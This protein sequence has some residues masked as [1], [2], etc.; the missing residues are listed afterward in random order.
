[1][2]YWD[3]VMNTIT[4][5]LIATAVL[6]ILMIVGVIVGV[7]IIVYRLVKKKFGKK[8][9]LISLMVIPL[10]LSYYIYFAIYPNDNFY[11]GEFRKIVGLKLPE[12]AEIL[13]KDASYHDL[14]GDYCSS[15]LIMLS[16]A[17]YQSILNFVKNDGKFNGNYMMMGSVQY[18]KVLGDLSENDMVY[19]AS[20]I[21]KED[22]YNF[23]G[24]FKDGKTIIIHFASS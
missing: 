5:I 22:R 1:M 14:H 12:S 8:P 24:F 7:I 23:I 21:E 6:F 16:E 9:A 19:E 11:R 18:N 15:A 10:I 17:E 13:R 2:V 20:Y 3:F 4:Y